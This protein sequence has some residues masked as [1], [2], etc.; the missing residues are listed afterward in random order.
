MLVGPAAK[1]KAVAAKHNLDISGFEIVDAP[2]S[3]AAAAKAVELIHAGQGRNADEGQPAHRR[4]DAQR[5]REGDWAA[6]RRGASVTSSSWT[7]RPI[8]RRCS[9][10]TL[11]SIFSRTSSAS[12]TSSRTR[13]ISIRR[14]AL[15]HAAG[16]H[17]V[18]GRDRHV[19]DS[20]D[21]RGRR[22]LQDG[23]PRT[24]H[25]RRCSMAARLRQRDRSGGG[26]GSRASSRRSR[27]APRSWSCRISRP[28]T[29]WPR[30]C[31]IFAK[32]DAAGIVL[33]A[34][35]PI[36]LTSRAD[37]RADPHGV[38][39]GCG[40][41]CRCPAPPRAD[42]RRVNAMDT[43]LVVN[44]GSS[45]VK[46]QVFAVD[47]R[48]QTATTG[49]GPDGR[50]WQPPAVARHWCRQATHLVDRVYPIESVPD[51]PAALMQAGSWLRDELQRR[52]RSPSAIGSFMAVRNMIAPVLIDHGVIAR[53][54]RL[55]AAGA[56]AP[57]A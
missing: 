15:A 3:E 35:V 21:H 14:S 22:A 20:V 43:I 29:C 2:H 41:L 8:P 50:N 56:A 32:A 37:S 23:G 39:R 5:H 12:A 54:E 48:R 53:L 16:R 42:S 24:D 45:S 6:H 34:R 30:I 40:A 57:A 9:S 26:A 38:L 52:A 25:R 17:P 51:V 55:R 31:R 1:I 44:A 10:P 18:G 46:F 7:C 49:Q 13:S 4:A 27:G 36:M 19:Q 11:R 33:G 47:R 28:A